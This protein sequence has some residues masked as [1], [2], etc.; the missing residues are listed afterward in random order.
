MKFYEAFRYHVFDENHLSYCTYEELLLWISKIYDSTEITIGNLVGEYSFH[1]LHDSI[2]IE[3]K[4]VSHRS[5][6]LSWQ[7]A[8]HLCESLKGMN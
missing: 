2:I 1:F 5:L 3:S 7:N 8:R 4:F 6:L